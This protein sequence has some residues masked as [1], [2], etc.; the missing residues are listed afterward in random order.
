MQH[1]YRTLEQVHVQHDFQ[2]GFQIEPQILKRVRRMLAALEIVTAVGRHVVDARPAHCNHRSDKGRQAIGLL[3]EIAVIIERKRNEGKDR[4]LAGLREEPEQRDRQQEMLPGHLI[5]RHKRVPRH[6]EGEQADVEHLGRCRAG[7]QQVDGHAAQERGCR[8]RKFAALEPFGEREEECDKAQD[9]ERVVDEQCRIAVGF[10]E[11]EHERIHEP[12]RLALEVVHFRLAVEN[13]I[14]PYALVTDAARMLEVHL[15]AHRFPARLVAQHA[16]RVADV[17]EHEHREENQQQRK[18]AEALAARQEG[19][20]MLRHEGDV[21]DHAHNQ[22]DECR[23]DGVVTPVDI[24]AASV[25]NGKVVENQE[26][27]KQYRDRDRSHH[28]LGLSQMERRN[29]VTQRLCQRLLLRPAFLLYRQILFYNRT[30]IFSSTHI[31]II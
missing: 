24:P 13:A 20:D 9:V 22:Q 19:A 29:P 30:L 1:L 26:G 11:I 12:E 6:E 2:I 14:G 21:H 10:H 17:A 8:Q 27:G 23:Q 18:P 25:R 4:L 28:R 3:E 15:Q 7:L 16:V 5:R 31:S